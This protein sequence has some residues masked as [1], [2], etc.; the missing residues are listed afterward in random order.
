VTVPN[1][2]LLVVDD[3]D[4]NRYALTHRLAR[5]GYPNAAVATNGREAL[6]ML[7]ARSFDLVLLD[8]MMPELDG[9]QVLE[10]M[11][12]DAVLRHVPVIMI[13]AISELDSVVRCIELGADEY[14]P[15]P[16]NRVLLRARIGACLE[17]KRLHDQEIVHLKEIDRH[18]QRADRLLHAILPAPA[19]A[20]LEATDR[21][22][23]RRFEGV[24]VVFGDIVGFTAYCDAHPPEEVV[25]NLQLLVE[26]FEDLVARRA[27]EKIKTVGD[28]VMATANLLIP[29]EDPVM[30][31]IGLSFD[32][33]A[34]ARQSPANWQLRTGIHFGPVVAG[35]VGRSKFSFDLWGDTVNV[36]AR[37]AAIGGP[38]IYVSGA[39]WT[40]V[41]GRC[42]GKCLGWVPLKGKSAVEVYECEGLT[43]DGPS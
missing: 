21:V 19:V 38:G 35:V 4:D 20:E 36:A 12:A 23:P 10:H 37:L 16:F 40:H 1:A 11:K 15:K 14:L 22:L 28:A 43:V 41:A 42:R 9:Y 33:A 8:V 30:A 34:A 5:E 3:N 31:S 18:R 7:A 24:A 25:S 32:L 2:A 6:N 29:H 17:R 27:M 39:A 26:T 13:S